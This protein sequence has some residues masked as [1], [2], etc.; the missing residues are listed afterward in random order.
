[1]TL[2]YLSLFSGI[3]GLDL[4]FDRAG[5]TCVGQ[6]EKN[7]FCQRVLAKHWP[8]VQKHDD[9]TTAV[10]WWRSAPRPHVDAVVGGYPCQ[11]ES[12]AGHRRAQ[13]DERWLWP[14]MARVVHALRPRFVVGE[15]V[16]GHRTRGLRFVLRDLDRLGYAAAPGVISAQEMGAPHLR[17]RIITIAERADLAHTDEERRGWW[18]EQE[19]QERWAQPADGGGGGRDG[20]VADAE[21]QSRN[22][23]RSGDA[24]QSPSRRD[25]DRGGVVGD[26]ADADR[27]GRGSEC[28]V[29]PAWTPALGTGWWATEPDVGRVAHGVPARVDRLRALGNAV[30]TRVGEHAG[31]LVRQRAEA[32]S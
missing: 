17:R 18:T 14:E 25:V 5:W 1:M 19:G 22:A 28:R 9:I 16:L 29:E 20:I 6:V 21:R 31:W 12:N 27:E 30:V 23:R 10:A 13:E 4:G 8:E 15:N 24:Q 32:S 26:V 3:G 2:N 11:G 7:E